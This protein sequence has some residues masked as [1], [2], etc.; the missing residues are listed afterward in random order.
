MTALG[1]HDPALKAIRDVRKGVQL[2]KQ[3]ADA[4]LDDE[5][6]GRVGLNPRRRAEVERERD[7][8]KA[9]ADSLTASIVV[10]MEADRASFNA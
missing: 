1:T 3:V 10:L 2:D 5:R 9:T 7:A 6:A 4:W 8:L